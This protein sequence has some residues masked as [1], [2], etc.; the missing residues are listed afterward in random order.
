M[1]FTGVEG[2]CMVVSGSVGWVGFLA[3]GIVYWGID[4]LEFMWLWLW[5]LIGVTPFVM[6]GL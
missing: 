4:C 3:L 1:W 6:S 2:G 5:R